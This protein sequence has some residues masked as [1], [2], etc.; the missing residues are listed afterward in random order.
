MNRIHVIHESEDHKTITEQEEI[1]SQIVIKEMS[2]FEATKK[3]SNNLEKTAPCLNYNQVRINGTREGFFRHG[4]ICPK[5]QKQT[6]W[7]KYALIFVC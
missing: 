2:L 1:R 3:G 4:T 7:W 6:E 5:T